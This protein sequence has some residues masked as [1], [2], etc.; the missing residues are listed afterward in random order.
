MYYNP[1]TKKGFLANK[2]KNQ[3]RQLN[4]STEVQ[5][6]FDDDLSEEKKEEYVLFFR[7]CVASKQS[8][9]IKTK[10]REV[11]RHKQSM[12]KL[13]EKDFRIICKCFVAMPELVRLN[14]FRISNGNLYLFFCWF[15]IL[16]AFGVFFETIDQRSLEEQWPDIAKKMHVLFRIDIPADVVPAANVDWLNFVRMLK[17]FSISR[18]AIK[19]TTAS[20]LTFS[21]VCSKFLKYLYQN[22]CV[23]ITFRINFR[24]RP[25]TP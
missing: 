13:F 24:A 12:M 25:M 3:S 17:Q 18:T 23:L 19:T 7:T 11:A 14:N 1:D 20:I 8:Q 16:Y 9:E 21:K 6:P 4:D 15:Q 5:E 2:F 22:K 10:L